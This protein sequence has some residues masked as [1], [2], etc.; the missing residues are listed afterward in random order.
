VEFETS[1]D[2]V[3]SSP[4][5]AHNAVLIGY[6]F[7]LINDF[8]VADEIAQGRLIRLLPDYEPVEQTLY[9]MFPHR[10]YLPAKV[11]VFVDY[12]VARFATPNENA[13]EYAPIG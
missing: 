5:A 7:T 12:L 8:S 2:F 9:A 11:R 6:G 10:R 1:D 13:T 3:V 4:G